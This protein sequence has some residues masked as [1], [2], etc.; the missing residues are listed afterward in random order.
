M[1]PA[2][3]HMQ[4][5]TVLTAR[6]LTE[7]GPIWLM[8]LAARKYKILVPKNVEFIT[9]CQEVRR[10]PIGSALE[11]REYHCGDSKQP[12]DA[13]FHNATPLWYK[14]GVKHSQ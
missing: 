12:F 4:D 1:N 13:I 5:D 9:Q 6:K 11:S 14:N 2:G 3:W 8:K 7:D 10:L